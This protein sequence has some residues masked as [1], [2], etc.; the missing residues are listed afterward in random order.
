M[1]HLAVLVV[2][3][4]WTWSVAA[5]AVGPPGTRRSV[6]PLSLD[7]VALATRW[8]S[9]AS[10]GLPTPAPLTGTPLPGFSG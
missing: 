6:P 3:E 9:D 4:R 10:R 8:A 2:G 1:V 7:Q 5:V